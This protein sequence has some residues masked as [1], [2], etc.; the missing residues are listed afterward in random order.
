VIGVSSKDY[1]LLV[2]GSQVSGLRFQASGLRSHGLMVSWSHVSW[3]HG[4][5]VTVI[6]PYH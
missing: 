6:N 5:M 4:L 3:S 2:V 1:K